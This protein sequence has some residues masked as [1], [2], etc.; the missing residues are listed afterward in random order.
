MILQICPEE[1]LG[2][3]NLCQLSSLETSKSRNKYDHNKRRKSRVT[4][5]AIEYIDAA[6]FDGLDEGGEVD[7]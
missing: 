3:G 2:K 5:E 4:E 1:K 7:E 6:G